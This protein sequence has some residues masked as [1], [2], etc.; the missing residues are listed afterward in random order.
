MVPA[1]MLAF[2][3]LLLWKT[4]IFPTRLIGCTLQLAYPVIL[5]K[6]SIWLI[7]IHPD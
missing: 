5:C 4:K 2:A 1:R 3:G 7:T 6:A